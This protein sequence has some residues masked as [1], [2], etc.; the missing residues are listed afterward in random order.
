MNS[1]KWILALLGAVVLFPAMAAGAPT[2][3]QSLSYLGMDN[4]TAGLRNN[5]PGNIR[6]ST[7]NWQGKIPLSQNTSGVFE[8]FYT[9]VYGVRAMIKNMMTWHSRGMNTIRLLVSKWA[10]PNEND[11]AAYIAYVA[12]QTGFGPDQV[13]DFSNKNTVKKLVQSMAA[14]ETG[15]ADAVTNAMFDYAYSLI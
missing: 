5:N 3:V 14:M 4:L 10:P 11:T 13:L 6:I 12:Q 9:Y 8:Q 1:E 15:K 2:D 7:T